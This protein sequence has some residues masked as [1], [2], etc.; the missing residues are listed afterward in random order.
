M[1]TIKENNL[2][3]KQIELIDVAI[4]ILKERFKEYREDEEYSYL[5]YN[6]TIPP[7]IWQILLTTKNKINF[8]P[9][10]ER[11]KEKYGFSTHMT[12]TLIHH[13]GYSDVLKN[14]KELQ[15]QYLKSIRR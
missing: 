7:H 11:I 1:N 2:Y 13:Y 8:K 9:L 15:K 4:D 12:R 3:D 5:F 10:I 6:K 14:G